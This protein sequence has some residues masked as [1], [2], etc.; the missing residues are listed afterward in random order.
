MN[1]DPLYR[2]TVLQTHP[3]EKDLPAGVWVT[4]AGTNHQAAW[5]TAKDTVKIVLQNAID[6]RLGNF[7]LAQQVLRQG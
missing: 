3:D 6:F 1:G 2:A 7:V 4:V 5:L